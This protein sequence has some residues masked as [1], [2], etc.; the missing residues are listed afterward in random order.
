MVCALKNSNADVLVH[1]SRTNACG[2]RGRQEK[3]TLH[4]SSSRNAAKKHVI[5]CP[6]HA[7]F[8]NNGFL[9]GGDRP[10]RQGFRSHGHGTQ[11]HCPAK[12]DT[13]NVEPRA[14][15]GIGK[16][17]LDQDT[18]LAVPEEDARAFQSQSFQSCS[19]IAIKVA[20]S[21]TVPSTAETGIE[22]IRQFRERLLL[23]LPTK[24]ARALVRHGT[25]D[26]SELKFGGTNRRGPGLSST[27]YESNPS[28]AK[29]RCNS[30]K[31]QLECHIPCTSTIEQ[32]RLLP[33]T[34]AAAE[35]R[36]RRTTK[37]PTLACSAGG[38]VTSR[39]NEPTTLPSRENAASG[40][41][42][43]MRRHRRW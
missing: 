36:T 23:K 12:N 31:Y 38:P 15:S 39:E 35:A 2:G 14:T 24:I 17:G 30:R 18:A 40:F 25:R 42:G 8:P 4:C 22:I 11:W 1:S 5:R 13:R 7:K 10:F 20:P 16:Q 9:L 21:P 3:N 26:T 6:Q 28:C 27:A 37:G 43:A 19:K 33:A 34:A 29:M 41:P 32:E